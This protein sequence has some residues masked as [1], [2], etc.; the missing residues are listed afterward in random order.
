MSPN[1]K[2]ESG[3]TP[4]HAAASYNNLEAIKLLIEEGALV[5]NQD[6]DGDTALHLSESST[7]A[8]LLISFGADPKLCNILGHL[9]IEIA[10]REGRE[11][12]VAYL[13]QFTP[14]YSI[15]VD[16]TVEKEIDIVELENSA[17]DVYEYAR[18]HGI[19]LEI[20]NEEDGDASGSLDR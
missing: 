10:Y 5:N 7:T 3:Y 17:I 14:D 2:D 12:V 15:L 11:D 8:Q 16:E 13:T 6:C 19:N 4:L 18:A 20:I 1:I 9:P